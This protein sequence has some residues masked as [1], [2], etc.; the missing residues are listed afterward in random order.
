MVLRVLPFRGSPASIGYIYDASLDPARGLLTAALALFS[1]QGHQVIHDPCPDLN[2]Y[3]S[4]LGSGATIIPVDNLLNHILSLGLVFLGGLFAP[5][6]V[7]ILRTSFMVAHLIS[8]PAPAILDPV[9]VPSTSGLVGGPCPPSPYMGGAP[10][11]WQPMGG[12][13]SRSLPMGGP[14]LVSHANMR[15]PP[16]GLAGVLPPTASA[17]STGPL[18]RPIGG[19][20]GAFGCLAGPLGRSFGGTLGAFSNVTVDVSITPASFVARSSLPMHAYWSLHLAPGYFPPTP[21][22]MLEPL[23]HPNP[24][25]EVSSIPVPPTPVAA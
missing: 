8:S 25:K 20:L 13:F 9:A 21:H 1:H 7:D 3:R 4:T 10:V 11:V 24:V 22:P 14:L 19:S 16:L 15:S 6:P 2:V 18:G 17:H 12:T 23:C 5:S